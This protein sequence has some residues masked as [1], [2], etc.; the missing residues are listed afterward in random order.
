M[1]KLM[2]DSSNPAAGNQYC[3]SSSIF[4]RLFSCALGGYGIT[5]GAVLDGLRRWCR[6][7]V[8][9]LGEAKTIVFL[10]RCLMLLF[11]S[12]VAA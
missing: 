7:E 12:I 4:P 9:G 10:D 11:I 6:G 3:F 5:P 2:C 8:R 1:A